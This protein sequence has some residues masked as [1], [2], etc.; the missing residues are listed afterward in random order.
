VKSVGKIRFFKFESNAAKTPLPSK[1]FKICVNT[2][3]RRE[4]FWQKILRIRTELLALYNQPTR[5]AF[6]L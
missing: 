1:K 6:Q 3:A 2:E 5:I 4:A